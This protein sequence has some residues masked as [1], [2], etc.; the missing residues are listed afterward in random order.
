MLS[1]ECPRPFGLPINLKNY[2]AG[3]ALSVAMIADISTNRFP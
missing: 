3:R 2:R 1:G